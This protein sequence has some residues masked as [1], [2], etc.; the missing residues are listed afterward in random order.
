MK[1]I[2][3][4]G[5]I[6]TLTVLAL[7]G[8][9][10]DTDCPTCPQFTQ[11]GL[12][13]FYANLYSNELSSFGILYGIDGKFVDV[14]SVKIDTFKMDIEQY[15]GEGMATYCSLGGGYKASS[16]SI[17]KI[18]SIT[19]SS[20]D[21]VELKIYTPSGMSQ[22]SVVILDDPNDSPVIYDWGVDYSTYDT[23]A[24]STEISV[25]WAPISNADYYVVDWRFDHNHDGV[26]QDLDTTFSVTDT[27]FV[28]PDSLL[29][30]DGRLYIYV[31]AINGPDLND[32]GN[33]TGGVIK[34]RFNSITDEYFRIYIGT[35]DPYPP[36]FIGP[37]EEEIIH[38]SYKDLLF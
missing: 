30:Y 9:S 17:D 10:D 34:G 11:E 2:L 29:G 18:S 26:R 32:N 22:A 15:F 6:L 20:G 19:Y 13:M 14:D 24:Q 1:K 21:T 36:S 7:S 27:S 35:G 12:A 23:V 3:I 25:A 37:R 4:L 33:L 31:Y 8:C 28:V 5:L 38:K 16:N